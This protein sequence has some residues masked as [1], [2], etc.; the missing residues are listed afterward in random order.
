MSATT[1][2]CAGEFGRAT[3]RWFAK[4]RPG[5]IV[6]DANECAGSIAACIAEAVY[7]IGV[8]WRPS[9]RLFNFIDQ[10]ARRSQKCFIPLVL[11]NHLLRLGPVSMPNREGCWSCAVQ[12][13]LQFD[14]AALYRAAVWRYY[15]EEPSAGP[16]GFLE[17]LSLLGAAQ[18]ARALRTLDAGEGPPSAVLEYDVLSRRSSV[19]PVAGV[20]DCPHCGLHR[21]SETSSTDELRH[22]IAYLWRDSTE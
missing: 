4:L 16:Q 7:V 12:R 3:A 6:I 11:D 2:I 1:V 14:S 8:A 21:V 10:H 20:H 5:A 15:D 22:A 17:S 19:H 9:V 18:L 13:Q